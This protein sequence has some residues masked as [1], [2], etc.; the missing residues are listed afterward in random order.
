M[1][2]GEKKMGDKL[3]MSEDKFWQ[4]IETMHDTCGED[5]EKALIWIRKELRKLTLEDVLGFDHMFLAY[6]EAADKYGLGSVASLMEQGCS[7]DGFIDFRAWL[8]S[9]GKKV[10][11]AALKN[12]EFLVNVKEQEYY[13]FEDLN[14][15]GTKVYMEKKEK[16]LDDIDNPDQIEKCREEIQS[17]IQYHPLIEYPLELQ[18][19]KIVFPKLAQ[20]YKADEQIEYMDEESIWN[21]NLPEIRK[22]W[23]KGKKEVQNWKKQ[24]KK[25]QVH[26]R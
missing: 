20:K 16:D 17:E 18:D 13:R 7:D 15:V 19:L 3:F 5:Q 2:R 8:I 25:K 6:R 10:Y 12:P 26:Q 23:E 21:L 1:R 24:K 11:L 9:Q 14:Y 4:L 22:L